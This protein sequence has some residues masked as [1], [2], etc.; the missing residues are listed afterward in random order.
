MLRTR[1]TRGAAALAALVLGGA[2][3]G[4]AGHAALVRHAV[5]AEHGEPVH[6]GS[7]G[8]GAAV[9]TADRH[10]VVPADSAAAAPDEHD[11]CKLLAGTSRIAP[12]ER[13]LATRLSTTG[14]AGVAARDT[15]VPPSVARFRLAPK[16]SPPVAG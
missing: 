2:E 6:A 5:C 8:A 3:L 14:D 7:A 13:G 15:I 11:H 10:A 1:M 9:T 16:N 4:S 12:R